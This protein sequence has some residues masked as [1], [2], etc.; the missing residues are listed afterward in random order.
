MQADGG[1]VEV[2]EKS[3]G[4]H[5]M[6]ERRLRRCRKQGVKSVTVLLHKLNNL[7][8]IR[9]SYAASI[10]KERIRRIDLGNAETTSGIGFEG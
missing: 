2:V 10:E 5:E 6:E 4:R 1:G 7:F 8:R 9:D 3:S